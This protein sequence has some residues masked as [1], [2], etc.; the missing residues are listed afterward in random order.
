MALE[1]SLPSEYYRSEEIFA[2]ERE[3]IFSR[4]WFCA[5]RSDALPEAG[6][7]PAALLE[8]EQIPSVAEDGTFLEPIEESLLLG[9][10]VPS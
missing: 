7:H 5:G 10:A 2:R 8:L 1:K 6:A 3:R 4:E 9:Q